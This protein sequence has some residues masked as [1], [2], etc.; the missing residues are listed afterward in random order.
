MD[1]VYKLTNTSKDE[2]RRFYIGAKEECSIHNDFDGVPTIFANTTNT[3]YYGSSQCPVMKS[4]LKAGHVFKAECLQVIPDRS[5]LYDTESEWLD[6]VR[7]VHS[8]DYYNISNHLKRVSNQDDV[9]NKYGETYKEVANRRSTV[10]RKDNKAV[11]LGYD[12]YG[13]MFYDWL[14][15]VSL[16][17]SGADIG[18][19]LGIHRH[20]V[21]RYLNG[22]TLDKFKDGLD[23]VDEKIAKEMLVQGATLKYISQYLNTHDAV[24]RK[25]LGS[26]NP[27]NDIATFLLSTKEEAEKKIADMVINRDMSFKEVAKELNISKSSASRY[28]VSYVKRRLKGCDL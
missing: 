14:L 10:S 13:E 19:S 25:V 3:P 22:M 18:R 23:T 15:R 5:N 20:F 6:K 8:E 28:F 11:S 2:G 1:I 12:N 21:T 27:K 24:V 17:E 7:A 26:F 16:G 4:D 9:L